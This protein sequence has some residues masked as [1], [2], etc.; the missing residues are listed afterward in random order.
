MKFS[1]IRD[2]LRAPF[3][4]ELVQWKPQATTRDKTKG[5]AVAYVDARSYQD[6]LNEICPDDW[7]VTLH[8]WGPN[9]VI[10]ELIICG[11]TRSSSGEGEE[12]DDNTATTAE[13][14]AF[15][16]ACSMFGLGRYL[17]SI[18]KKWVEYD[19]KKRCFTPAALKELAK[20]A[21]ATKVDAPAAPHEPEP[22]S[23]QATQGA[24]QEPAKTT[25][26]EAPS[27][28]SKYVRPENEKL[29]TD[30]VTRMKELKSRLN[31]KG[32]DELDFYIPKWMPEAREILDKK[33]G[34][35]EPLWMIITRDN[36]ESIHQ[37]ITARLDKPP[38]DM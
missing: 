32:N 9:Q 22:E 19:E 7:H 29:T 34:P 31:V 26:T 15:K 27:P 24:Q 25:V 38:E 16:R 28:A 10:C 35:D 13:A 6:R 2:K 8:A 33:Y 4:A 11:V 3:A 17:Y 21:A 12:K 37:T 14:Q 18:P 20:L 1:E 36:F 30:Q 5:M 23:S